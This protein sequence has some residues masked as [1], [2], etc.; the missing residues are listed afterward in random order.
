VSFR[1]PTRLEVAQDVLKEGYEVQL[2]TRGDSMVPLSRSGGFLRVKAVKPEQLRLGDVIVYRVGELLVAH[3]LVRIR[4]EGGLLRLHSKGDA[5]SW[6]VWEEVAP[7]QVLGRVTV[8]QGPRGR[9][10]RIDAGWGRVLSLILAA[11]WPLPQ[12]LFRIFVKCKTVLTKQSQ[13]VP[14]SRT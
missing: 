9:E 10:V 8:V 5:F 13:A 3:R 7:E 1:A 14:D 6:R 4:W 2:V 12:W 11:T